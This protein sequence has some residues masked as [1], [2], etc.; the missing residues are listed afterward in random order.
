M[1][2]KIG[3]L[4]IQNMDFDVICHSDLIQK[5]DESYET[6][7]TELRCSSRTL[8]LYDEGK[9]PLD[10][11]VH[12][13]INKISLDLL[14]SKVHFLEGKPEYK[15]LS[16][17]DLGLYNPVAIDAEGASSILKIDDFF[18]ACYEDCVIE[19]V[20]SIRESLAEYSKNEFKIQF[21]PCPPIFT[22]NEGKM[23]I[24]NAFSL[25]MIDGDADFSV[26]EI[27]W[28]EAYNLIK[29]GE[30][31]IG[32]ETLANVLGVPFNRSTIS[33]EKGETALVVQYKG[34]RLPEGATSL[35]DGAKLIPRLVRVK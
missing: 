32:H 17:E 13:F 24:L 1:D 23:K 9:L 29:K 28:D 22:Q 21:L 10:Y 7:P 6:V 35:P 14:R 8:Y 2:K 31:Y 20:Q 12:R 18:D 11:H 16:F 3:I 33:L 25:N 26:C 15:E 27:E 34:E 4:K 5:A 30:S 19:N